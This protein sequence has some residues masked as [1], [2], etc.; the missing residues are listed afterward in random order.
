MAEWVLNMSSSDD[1]SDSSNDGKPQN[2]SEFLKKL[3]RLRE[4]LEQLNVINASSAVYLATSAA[5]SSL[6]LMKIGNRFHL[7]DESGENPK[8]F[9]AIEVPLSNKTDDSEVFHFTGRKVYAVKKETNYSKSEEE[10]IYSA[11]REMFNLEPNNYWTLKSVDNNLALINYNPNTVNDRSSKEISD[12]YGKYRGILI[13]YQRKVTIA[14]SY[15]FTPTL[16]IDPSTTFVQEDSKLVIQSDNVKISY[17]SDDQL[18]MMPYLQGRVVRVSWWDG[19]AHYSSH[20]NANAERAKRIDI[21]SGEKINYVQM[22]NDAGG[23][24]PDK[25]FNTNKRFS[26]FCY[27]FMVVHPVFLGATRHRTKNPYCVFMFK[28]RVISNDDVERLNNLD[29][30]LSISNEAIETEEKTY[31][32]ETTRKLSAEMKPFSQGEPIGTFNIESYS[33]NDAKNHLINGF[34]TSSN[35][36]TDYRRKLGEALIV[37]RRTKTG[38]IYK[39]EDMIMVSS[40]SYA[41]REKIIGEKGIDIDPSYQMRVLARQARFSEKDEDLKKA[42]REKFVFYKE[43]SSSWGD[44]LQTFVNFIKNSY[45]YN[46]NSI[47]E[48][49]SKIIENV[50]ERLKIA[51]YNLIICLPST[52]QAKNIDVLQNYQTEMSDLKN[53]II[54]LRNNYKQYSFLGRRIPQII[55]AASKGNNFSNSVQRF[56]YNEDPSSLTAMLRLY[57]NYSSQTSKDIPVGDTSSVKKSEKKVGKKFAKTPEKKSEKKRVEVIRPPMM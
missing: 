38:E 19:K 5:I 2:T 7:L 24:S 30:G 26:V 18:I 1:E 23:P 16:I 32:L 52:L 51:F 29:N 56:L 53:W 25:L 45:L 55:I 40:V 27:V 41:Y 21:E 13:D 57:K 10:K 47:H 28:H 54:S 8:H 20:N 37:Y 34:Y 6:H 33:F 35:N 36:I 46:W 14:S 22:F 4:L 43:Y 3:H 39:I 48:A 11:I 12:R 31:S 15:H 9:P 17:P 49:N 50:E 44:E 42:F